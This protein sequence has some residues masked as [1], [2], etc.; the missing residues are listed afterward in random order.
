MCVGTYVDRLYCCM[1]WSQLIVHYDG[2][3]DEDHVFMM[4]KKGGGLN[5]YT[6]TMLSTSTRPG[7][8]LYKKKEGAH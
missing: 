4:M 3:E 1:T 5:S 7:E 6:S 8:A 2:E